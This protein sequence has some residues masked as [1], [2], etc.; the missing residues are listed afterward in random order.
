MSAA[1]HLHG[2]VS[3]PWTHDPGTRVVGFVAGDH[4][5]QPVLAET[6]GRASIT[7]SCG[8]FDATLRPTSAELRNLAHM[9]TV[10]ADRLDM[11]QHP[12]LQPADEVTS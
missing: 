3:S 1:P 4:L 6:A 7:L 5:D 11:A 12:V 8:A 2:H 9:C 10:L